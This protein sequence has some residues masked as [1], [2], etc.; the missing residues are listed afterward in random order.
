MKDNISVVD[1]QFEDIN[2]GLRLGNCEYIV[3]NVRGGLCC[4]KQF[5]SHSENDVNKLFM[6]D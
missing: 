1:T 4:L 3:D 6:A 2:F 5:F